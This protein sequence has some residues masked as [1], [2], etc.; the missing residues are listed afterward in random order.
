MKAHRFVSRRGS[1]IFYTVIML[2]ALRAGRSLPPRNI[3][4]TRL[5]KS[6]S[7]V[8]ELDQLKKMQ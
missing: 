8:E 3:S 5:F 4:G 1:H 7:V 6:L 2:S